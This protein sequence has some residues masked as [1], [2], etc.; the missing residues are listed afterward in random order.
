MNLN[1][2]AQ[3]LARGEIS[4]V[5][6]RF[7]AVR[8]AYSGLMRVRD[9][10]TRRDES[11]PRGDTAFPHIS[12]ER[13]VADLSKNAVARGFDL[14]AELSASLEQYAKDSPCTCTGDRALRFRW[15][16]VS[17]GRLPTGH[18]VVIG[19]VQNPEACPAVARLRH[20][21][22]LV[23]VI[24][25]YLGYRPRIAA[26]RLY[27][28]FRGDVPDAERRRRNQTI[29]YHFDVF[30]FNFVY[31]SFYLTDVDARSGAHALI[32]AS[33]RGKPLRLLLGSANQPAERVFAHFDKEQELI[34]EG[35][36]GTGFVEDASCFHRALAPVD[37]D[38]LML[39]I[40]F[41]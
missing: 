9:A 8:R 26:P 40:R 23:D 11:S 15:S 38:R 30:G 1:T 31:A 18:S 6:G 13:A 37:R 33:H 24:A 7:G 19:S 14:P 17:E 39:Q 41:S 36:K 20:D 25:R 27:W 10:I 29:D 4:Y 3:R 28:S 5:L 21:P 12:V 22:V 32:R 2:V 16:D 34:I 35:P